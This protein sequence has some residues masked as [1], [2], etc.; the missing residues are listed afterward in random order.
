[1]FTG[2]EHLD[3]VG[4]IH[5]NGRVYDPVAGRF[6][7]SDPVR[8]VGLSQDANP[9][10]YAWNNPLSVQDRNGFCED[11]TTGQQI[12]CPLD[13]VDVYGD[14]WDECDWGGPWMAGWS[15]SCNDDLFLDTDDYIF[16]DEGSG[17]GG[18]GGNGDG[19]EDNAPPL[20]EKG[21]SNASGAITGGVVTPA[22]GVLVTTGLHDGHGFGTGRVA[23]GWGA[24]ASYNPKGGLPVTP[25]NPYGSGQMLTVSAQFGLAFGIPWTPLAISFKYEGGYNISTEDGGAVINDPDFEFA[26][27]A[28]KAVEAHANVGASFTAYGPAHTTIIN[29]ETCRAN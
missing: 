7:S 12:P 25:R 3:S 8:V 1:G 5:M 13:P 28:K 15:Q 20:C 14:P 6:L 24:A 22:G 18:G 17:G 23:W 10:A 27:K 26:W 21:P 19:N 11:P 4:L 2:H 9:Y 29:S 16:E